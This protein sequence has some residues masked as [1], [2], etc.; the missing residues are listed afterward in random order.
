MQTSGKLSSVNLRMSNVFCSK[1][2]SNAAIKRDAHDYKRRLCCATGLPVVN[3]SNTTR[4]SQFTCE[5]WIKRAFY[6]PNFN[7]RVKIACK[8][9]LFQ[10]YTLCCNAVLYRI[11]A[12]FVNRIIFLTIMLSIRSLRARDKTITNRMRT[13]S[14]GNTLSRI[15]GY[16]FYLRIRLSVGYAAQHAGEPISRRHA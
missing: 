14:L 1:K 13:V 3:K 6:G 8:T 11:K 16:F 9:R 12:F 4:L 15:R 2:K 7:N 5:L 10:R